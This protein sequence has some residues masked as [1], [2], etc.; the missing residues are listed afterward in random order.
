[1]IELLTKPHL[2]FL[3]S[4]DWKQHPVFHGL[5]GCWPMVEGGGNR[6]TDISGYMNHGTINGATWVGTPWGPGL[7]F[8]GSDDYVNCGAMHAWGVANTKTSDPPPQFT[9]HLGFSVVAWCRT[10][11]SSRQAILAS[12]C[13]GF[14]DEPEIGL[15][16][17]HTS[18]G[19]GESTGNHW[20][21][22]ILYTNK[23]R[24]ATVSSN[25]TPYNGEWHMI[26]CA[27]AGERNDLLA[28]YLDGEDV[29]A[30]TTTDTYGYGE[31]E[32]QS[33]VAIGATSDTAGG[34]PTYFFNGQMT[35][36]MMWNRAIT[37][38]EAAMLYRLGPGG[39]FRNEFNPGYYGAINLGTPDFNPAWTIN[40]NQV[41]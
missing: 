39:I 8:D 20:G 34:T 14:S 32:I 13:L 2:G 36:V 9:G 38:D 41:L 10:S 26:G 28:F 15:L 24:V 12:D 17:N 25:S 37:A 29:T 23:D 16:L 7:S 19:W 11:S 40:C 22:A 5:I 35:L 4:N 30:A 3:Q 21:G 1:M 18:T 33:Y 6:L 27:N 31:W